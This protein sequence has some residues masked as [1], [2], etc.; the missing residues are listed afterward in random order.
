VASESEH[1]CGPVEVQFLRVHK[2]DLKAMRPSERPPLEVNGT[3][4]SV[5][6]SKHNSSAGMVFFAIDGC[7]RWKGAARDSGLPQSE[8]GARLKI[9]DFRPG[10][11]VLASLLRPIRAEGVDVKWQFVIKDAP[12]ALARAAPPKDRAL[13]A[14]RCEVAAQRMEMEAMRTA[15]ADRAEAAEKRVAALA[16]SADSAASALASLEAAQRALE[17]R[18]GH[19]LAEAAKAQACADAA[20][21]AARV[22]AQEALDARAALA[23]RAADAQEAAK[24][25]LTCEQHE[26]GLMRAARGEAKARGLP[27]YSLDGSPLEHFQAFRM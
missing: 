26:R 27:F 4:E 9:S 13:A 22:W 7:P 11:R 20:L 21:Q 1:A 12:S 3:V 16:A 18:V 6:A 5:I 2:E 19:A 14:L 8:V 15:F 24:Y 17:D 25:G 23:R 10:D